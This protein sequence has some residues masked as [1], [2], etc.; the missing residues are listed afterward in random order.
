M[1]EG[2]SDEGAVY[3][4]PG[5]ISYSGNLPLSLSSVFVGNIVKIR[6]VHH[7]HPKLHCYANSE[8]EI[9]EVPVHPNTWFTVRMFDGKRI[10]VRASAF[11]CGKNGNTLIKK[12]YDDSYDSPQENEQSYSGKY[13]SGDSNDSAEGEVRQ[14]IDPSKMIPEN[15]V[16]IIPSSDV[17]SKFSQ[18]S[19]CE[20]YVVEFPVHPNTWF[21]IQMDNGKMMKL[22]RNSIKFD[23]DPEDYEPRTT[24]RRISEKNSQVAED[25]FYKG[26]VGQIATIKNGKE[27][28][29]E[30]TIVDY[31]QG[32]FKIRVGETEIMKRVYHIDLSRK[33]KQSFEELAEKRAKRA[34]AKA[35]VGHEVKIIGGKHKEKSG[36]VVKGS[37]GFCVV[38]MQ[39]SGQ[40]IMKRCSDLQLVREGDMDCDNSLSDSQNSLDISWNVQIEDCDDVDV[41]R[42]NEILEN[43]SYTSSSEKREICGA[44]SVLM[45]IFSQT[46]PRSTPNSSPTSSNVETLQS[47]LF[48]SEPY[49]SI[50]GMRICD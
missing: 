9:T 27:A 21:T 46:S 12:T 14:P 3:Q 42:A 2:M 39:E 41:E 26:F 24:S 40:L 31:T 16:K 15:R 48:S 7:L 13:Y 6:S 32:F 17:V 1:A 50:E 35:M 33:R 36:V 18:F 45:N 30:G 23:S 47:D 37:N 38:E 4:E 25:D 11:D 22:R 8:A 43:F 44:A 20:G 10:K 34:A 28:G 5:N 19:G 29:L 49:Q